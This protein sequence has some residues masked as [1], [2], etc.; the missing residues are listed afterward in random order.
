MRAIQSTHAREI[1]SVNGLDGRGGPERPCNE[2]LA[3]EEVLE[4]EVGL[5]DQPRISPGWAGNKVGDVLND[6]VVENVGT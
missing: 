2:E 5:G 1:H 4:E 6:D 3:R